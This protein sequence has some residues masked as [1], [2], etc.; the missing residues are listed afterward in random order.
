MVTYPI[1]GEEIELGLADYELPPLKVVT[2]VAHG[3]TPDSP[4]RVVLEADDDDQMCFQL[5]DWQS[6]AD[7]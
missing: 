3:Q 6:P 7:S 2:I 1:F 4:A 5:I